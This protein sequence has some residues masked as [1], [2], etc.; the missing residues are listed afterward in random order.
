MQAGWASALVWTSNQLSAAGLPRVHPTGHLAG[1]ARAD[2]NALVGLPARGCVA[3]GPVVRG[4]WAGH[5]PGRLRLS[6]LPAINRVVDAA[7]AATGLLFGSRW[8]RR[9]FGSLPHH[10]TSSGGEWGGGGGGDGAARCADGGGYLGRRVNAAA[11][12]RVIRGGWGGGWRGV[13]T[14]RWCRQAGG[15][16]EPKRTRDERELLRGRQHAFVPAG[17]DAIT[18]SGGALFVQMGGRG[19]CQAPPQLYLSCRVGAANC[20]GGCLCARL[21]FGTG[22]RR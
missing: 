22:A 15:L 21:A 2:A 9:G 18:P 16:A 14:R 17:G 1:S 3:T 12:D 8:C 6:P 11:A 20:G 5:S 7:A 4:G 13:F 10:S 19:R